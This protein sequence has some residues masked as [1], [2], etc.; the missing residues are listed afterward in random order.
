[1]RKYAI[2]CI[3]MLFGIS[4]VSAMTCTDL[5]KSIVRRQEDSS[6]LALQTF[7]FEKGLLKVT[8]NGY[9][10][11]G[12]FAAVK[13]YQLSKGFEPIGNVGPSTRAA[14]KKDSCLV[15]GAVNGTSVAQSQGVSVTQSTSVT[16][17]APLFPSTPQGTRNARRKTDAE[18]ILKGLYRYF[19]DSRGVHSVAV[20]DTPI[21]LCVPPVVVSTIATSSEGSLSVVTPVSPC[22]DYVDVSYLVPSYVKAVPRD[23]SSATTSIMTGYT[24][25]RSQYNDITIAAKSPE[26]GAIIKVSCNFNGFCKDIKYISTLTYDQPEIT[27]INRNIFLRDATPRT[28]LIIK[29]K[30]FTKKNRIKLFSLY[31][32]K[33]YDL[34]EFISTNYTATTTSISIET[35]IF[36][37]EFPCGSNCTAKLPLG[38]YMLSIVNEGGVSNT[39]RVALR[40]FTTS[41]IST[42]VN[43]SIVPTTK[44]V[45][46]ATIT[47]SSSIPVTLK[48]LTLTSTST[49]KNLASKITNFVLKDASDGTTIAGGNGTFSFGNTKLFENQ[50][51]VYDVYVDTAE[52]LNVDAGFI[53]YGGNF[54]MSDTF[55]YVEMEL[56]IKEFSFTVSH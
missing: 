47:L 27:S 38:D 55:A 33:E 23:P 17:S 13:A 54:L 53:T 41:T 18:T 30:N 46:V 16:P 35:P 8:P 7:L 51:K 52:V 39:T 29:G 48:T 24:I 36:A 2:V 11:V 34:G 22:A 5:T 10:G 44:N 3:I 50:S 37:Q 4:S 43:G 49:S 28:P 31:N 56:P 45:K 15:A 12:T 26:D 25:T 19:V 42:Q 14:I 20:T 6:V 32:S 21:E 1:M 9:F 40:G